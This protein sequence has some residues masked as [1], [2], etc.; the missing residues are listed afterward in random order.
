MA[1]STK[2]R[3]NDQYRGNCASLRKGAWWYKDC[4]RSNLN[5]MYHLGK[6]SSDGDGVNWRTWRGYFYSAKR[7]EMKIRPVDF[8]WRHDKHRGHGTECK[9]A[10]RFCSELETFRH[11]TVCAKEAL[12]YKTPN[13][14]CV[15]FENL[16][17]LPP[18]IEIAD[19]RGIWIVTRVIL[20]LLCKVRH[21]CFSFLPW[22]ANKDQEIRARASANSKWPLLLWRLD[23]VFN[24]F[25]RKEKNRL[26][27]VYSN[28]IMSG[29]IRFFIQEKLLPFLLLL[30]WCVIT[31]AEQSYYSRVNKKHI[32]GV[33][34]TPASTWFLHR[35]YSNFQHN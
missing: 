31:W 4:F 23:E 32:Q 18:R 16:W 29:E 27:S 12:S 34:R 14:T 21:N 6:H 5:A 33:P 13:S 26:F 25:Y 15:H 8:W 30:L 22:L 1:F 11:W 3:D 20:V 7:A 28:K 35:Y 17:L 19:P 2:D 9:I 10:A 24:V